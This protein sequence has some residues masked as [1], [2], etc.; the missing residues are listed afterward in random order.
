MNAYGDWSV[1]DKN[2]TELTVKLG[3]LSSGK[4]ATWSN[5][6]LDLIESIGIMS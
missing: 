6:P 3:P 2:S 4:D 1:T 5:A